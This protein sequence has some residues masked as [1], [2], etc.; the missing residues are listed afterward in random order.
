MGINNVK[1]QNSAGTGII[2]HQNF[3]KSNNFIDE[4]H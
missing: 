1:N 3:K 4:S 2:V